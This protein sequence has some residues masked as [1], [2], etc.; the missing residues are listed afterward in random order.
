MQSEFGMATTWFSL[1]ELQHLLSSYA[2]L[3]VPHV[4]AFVEN[5]VAMHR[6][7]V[8]GGAVDLHI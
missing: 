5:T 2:V 6:S 1:P 3:M 8:S 4:A 7:I